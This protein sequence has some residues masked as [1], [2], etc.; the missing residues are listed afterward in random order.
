MPGCMESTVPAGQKW[1]VARRI[2]HRLQE[3]GY[4]AY[5]VGGCLR[6]YLLGRPIH[7]I[8]IATN[9]RPENVLALFPKAFPTGLQHG[10][11]TVVVDGH[12]FEVTTFR[13]ESGYRQ[14]RWPQVT[15]IDDLHTDLARRDFTI[16]A[17]ALSPD[18]RWHDPFGGQHDLRRRLIRAVGQAEQRF[19][20]DALRMLRAIRFAAQLD[21]DIEP[22]TWAAIRQQAPLL[23][24]ISMERIQ[25]ELHRTLQSDHPDR[26]MQLLQESGLKQHIRPLAAFAHWPSETFRALLGVRTLASRWAVLFLSPPPERADV[27]R[28]I[29]Q[30][31]TVLRQMKCSRQLIAEVKTMLQLFKALQER[32]LPLLLLDY[33]DEDVE[34]AIRLYGAVHQW[35]DE[36]RQ[37][38]LNEAAAAAKQLRIRS[39]KQMVV[40]GHD[41]LHAL[42]V[43][44]GP[45]MKPLLQRL[46]EEVALGLLDNDKSAILSRAITLY[47]ESTEVNQSAMEQSHGGQK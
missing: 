26:G 17:M 45:W 13:H 31:E 8:D 1:D 25:Q 10:T 47:R 19:A 38:W 34:E 33:R 21:F 27:P 32:E 11:V 35:P 2:T 39:P 44:P 6:D 20:E 22:N 43:A 18:G 36:Q 41:V 16:N 3:A 24:H 5:F 37:A 42:G 46:F 7:D 29:K 4:E 23:A 15:Y 14:H 30:A 9:A 40:D 28:C 12:A